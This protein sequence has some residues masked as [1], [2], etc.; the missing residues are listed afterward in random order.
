L[1]EK[2]KSHQRTGVLS[3]RE[4]LKGRQVPDRRR[5]AQG[6]AV[7]IECVEEI[8]C[9]PCAGACPRGAI[10]VAPS[11]VS[12]PRVDYAKCNGCALCVARCPGLAIF[13]VNYNYSATE[14][15]VT[16]PWE[17]LPRP[18]KDGQVTALDR[19]GKPV[20][21]ARVVRVLDA[22]VLDRCAVVTLAVPKRLW[23]MV[24]SFRIGRTAGSAG[25]APA[26]RA[27]VGRKR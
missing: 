15:T 23:K 5:L 14:A 17:M 16:I 2:L 4:L 22:K 1:A 19:A 6:P 27:G 9:N 25:A 11:L 3:E 13:V 12:L 26:T 7:V 18:D 10:T 8:P 24:R 20:G 21:R